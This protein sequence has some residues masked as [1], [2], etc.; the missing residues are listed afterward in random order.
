MIEH[1]MMNWSSLH[2][3]GVQSLQTDLAKDV[4]VVLLGYAGELVAKR[5]DPSCHRPEAGGY[6]KIAILSVSFQ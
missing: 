4:E 6:F 2:V 3:D 5:Y 1:E